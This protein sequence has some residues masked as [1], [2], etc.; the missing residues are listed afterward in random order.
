V[1]GVISFKDAQL[2]KYSDA[3]YFI[4]RKS[5]TVTQELID[6]RPLEAVLTAANLAQ[7]QDLLGTAWP[8][9]KR[10]TSLLTMGIKAGTK[11]AS[12]VN[13]FFCKS[14]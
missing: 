11:L 10:G 9:H 2:V 14:L 13:R 6:S 8:M 4:D 5:P 3:M 7:A 1:G 12:G